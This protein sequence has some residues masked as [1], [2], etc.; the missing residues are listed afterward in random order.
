MNWSKISIVGAVLFIFI[1]WM[2]I[3]PDELEDPDDK[4]FVTF[5]Y[6]CRL[7]VDDEDVP[8]HVLEECRKLFK[9]L[10]DEL[11]KNKSSI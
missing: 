10:K 8:Q 4:F 5:T 2:Y 6:D 3:P 11:S 7:I 1:F 9:E